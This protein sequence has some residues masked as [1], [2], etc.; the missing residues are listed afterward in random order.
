M[1]VRTILKLRLLVGEWNK[2]DNSNLVSAVAYL[3]TCKYPA[4]ICG[5]L[6]IAPLS[7]LFSSWLLRCLSSH[8]CLPSAG[9]SYSRC[10]IASGCTPLVPLVHSGWLLCSLSPLRRLVSASASV[11]KE[12]SPSRGVDLD[13]DTKLHVQ[14]Q[15]GNNEKNLVVFWVQTESI[16]KVAAIVIACIEHKP[17]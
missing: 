16:G 4:W 9:V 14:H 11:T 8:Q 1:L 10:A 17:E 7:C 13:C 2:G 5:Y 12:L 6:T 15:A 3:D